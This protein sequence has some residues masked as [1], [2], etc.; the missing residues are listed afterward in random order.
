MNQKWRP[1]LGL[2]FLIV[3]ASIAAA[4]FYQ[5]YGKT[6]DYPIILNPKFKY[7]TKDP[8]TGDQKPFLWEVTYT[9]G[10]NDSAFIRHDVI[11]GKECLGLHVYQDGANDTYSWANIHVKQALRG[12][13]ASRFFSSKIGLWV[14]PTFSY[15]Q[16]PN[17]KEPGN[18]FGIEI[19]DGKH[20]LWFIFSDSPS[21]FYQLRNHRI[22]LVNAAL[23]Q[24]THVQIDV[25]SHYKQ[26][27]WEEPSDLS[28]ILISGATKAT[29]GN[30]AGY[31]S[32]LNIEPMTS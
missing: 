31:Y 13:T 20:L 12:Q 7:F 27:G 30:Y 19:N 3:L 11:E 24:W 15:A 16:D 29:P 4:S 5:S 10:P 32:E 26:A 18:V 9:I 21:G 22:V 23:N 6:N 25:L 28:F 17:S 2:V 8:I 1:I 14:Y